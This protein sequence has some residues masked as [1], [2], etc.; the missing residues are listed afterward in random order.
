M[1]DI[2]ACVYSYV[3]IYVYGPMYTYMYAS[4]YSTV[5][6]YVLKPGNNLYMSEYINIFV[7]VCMFVQVCV[8]MSGLVCV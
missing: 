2:H 1:C 3:H 8:H 7:Y 4:M 6:T 5:Q